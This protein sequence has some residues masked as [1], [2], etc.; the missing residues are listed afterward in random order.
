MYII[1]SWGIRSL[2]HRKSSIVVHCYRSSSC[3]GNADCIGLNWQD[4]FGQNILHLVW[5]TQYITHLQNCIQSNITCRMS[6]HSYYSGC[7][8]LGSLKWFETWHRCSKIQNNKCHYSCLAGTGRTTRI[9]FHLISHWC[10][11]WTCVLA[12]LQFY[13]SLRLLAMPNLTIF[14]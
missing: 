8:V 11:A 10:L 9:Q 5:M 12:E 1:M 2:L 6:G 13:W 4:H 3:S 7:N 14:L